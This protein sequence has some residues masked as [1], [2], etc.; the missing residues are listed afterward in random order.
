MSLTANLGTRQQPS[1]A[2]FAV[3][4]IALVSAACG[5]QVGLDDSSRADA[6]PGEA[7][8]DGRGGHVADARS[9]QGDSTTP[10]ADGPSIADANPGD[11][12]VVLDGQV[13]PCGVPCSTAT[14]CVI[15]SSADGGITQARCTPLG[16][17][18]PGCTGGPEGFASPLCGS[19]S[20]TLCVWD[21]FYGSLTLVECG[22]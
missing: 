20:T 22:S 7:S 3:L 6:G 16:S 15:V 14:A 19:S 18:G 1:R 21:S 17:A 9:G 10:P 2:S 12:A 13:G 4:L 5:G 8:T 11:S